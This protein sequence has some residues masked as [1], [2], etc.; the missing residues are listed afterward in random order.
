MK[1]DSMPNSPSRRALPEVEYTPESS[2]RHPLRLFAA[3]GRDVLASRELAW[4]L[5][6]RDIRAHYRQSVFGFAWIFLP[7]LVLAAGFTL[8]GN[9]NVI[10]IAATEFPYPA[11][12]MFSVMLWQ[13]FV[14][15][16]NGP[17]QA[18]SNA[19]PMLARIN[20]PSEALL[21]AKLGEVVFNFAVKLILIVAIFVWY[22]MPI[23]WNA[24][25]SPLALAQLIIFGTFFGLL[26]APLGALYQDVAYGLAV[27]TSLWMFVTPVV[28]PLPTTGVFA[29]IVRANPVTPLLMTTRELAT[30]GVISD[31]Y[32]FFLVSAI[33]VAG[34]FLTWI[35][36]R[37]AL[38]FV[39]ERVGS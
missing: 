12:V 26:L 8:A 4:R 23:T 38:P 13:T 18:V 10:N 2:L 15:A 6:V 34:L 30:T 21:L 28:F 29:T 32:R 17:V 7:P 35:G 3:M 22:N 5:L 31:P 27:F 1:P 39:I 33:A 36:F 37:L 16:L 25:F 14:D 11:Y 9:S 24:L 19:K 20:F